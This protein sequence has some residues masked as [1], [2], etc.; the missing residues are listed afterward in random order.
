MNAFDY[1]KQEWV[2]GDD[3]APLRQ[4]Q[5]SEELAILNSPR[6]AEYLRFTGSRKTV[7]EAR[8]ACRR[9]LTANG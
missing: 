5:L 4:A 6:A 3:A 8:A 9:Q 7:E 1:E 2:D